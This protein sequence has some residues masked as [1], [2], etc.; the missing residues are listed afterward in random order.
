MPKFCTQIFK[1]D[2]EIWTKTTA[3]LGQKSILFPKAQCF[4]A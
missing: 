1:F 3:N 4:P 2:M